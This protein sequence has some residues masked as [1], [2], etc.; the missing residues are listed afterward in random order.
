MEARLLA[1]S[2]AGL[3]DALEFYSHGA[4]SMS[5]ATVRLALPLSQ[6][7][8][9]GIVV[10]GEDDYNHEVVGTVY[11][12][13]LV[14]DAALKFKYT[15]VQNTTRFCRVGTLRVGKQDVHGC[16]TRENTINVPS[17]G[18]MLAYTY[19]PYTDNDN[20]RTLQS[21]SLDAN[22]KFYE[23]K[24]CP[25]ETFL[26]VCEKEISMFS[27]ILTLRLLILGCLILSIEYT[28]ASP[29]TPTSGLLPLSKVEK[30]ISR[31]VI[32]ISSRCP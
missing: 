2:D 14:D 29:L 30:L 19:D 24:N 18:A 9:A 8:K 3:Q 1:N 20:G 22:T 17:T 31:T 26:K 11:E 32:P 4:H 28:S 5:I 12:N 6:P 15:L 7:L 13:A 23:C 27:K 16:L 10:I 25:Y 21:L